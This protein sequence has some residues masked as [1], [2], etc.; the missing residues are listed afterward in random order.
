MFL[1]LSI[2]KNNK[3]KKS[4]QPQTNKSKFINCP[5]SLLRHFTLIPTWNKRFKIKQFNLNH[6]R[7]LITSVCARVRARASLCNE[8]KSAD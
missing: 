8:L 7:P 1:Y 5:F 3:N 4:H 6:E 2:E